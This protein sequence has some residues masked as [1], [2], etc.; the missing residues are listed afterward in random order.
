M[1]SKLTQADLR[2][3]SRPASNQ[4]VYQECPLC[5]DRGWHFY[6]NSTTGGWDCKKCSA[7][8]YFEG[9]VEPT[10]VLAQLDRN[11]TVR[12]PVI[13]APTTV[14]LTVEALRYLSDRGISEDFATQLGL[15]SV[16]HR[17]V[18]I[19]FFN[20]LGELIWWT[21]RKHHSDDSSPKYLGAS[22]KHPLY[23]P[24]RPL[25]NV[26]KILIVEGPF[27]A[28]AAAQA[29]YCG[30]ALSGKSLSRHLKAELQELLTPD[31]LAYIMLDGSNTTLADSFKLIKQVSRPG[32]WITRCPLGHDPASLGAE[33]IR[34]IIEGE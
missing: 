34:S 14:A 24:V 10:K 13:D 4:T 7:S 2:G 28:I 31:M 17:R 26:P 33:G 15:R 18:F 25:P 27:D 20:E 5:R 29:G 8:G 1:S 12:W 3:D 9:R 23:I 32:V 21:S 11:L 22:G 30:V 19:P 16:D 6:T